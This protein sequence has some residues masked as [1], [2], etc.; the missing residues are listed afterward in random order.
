MNVFIGS[1]SEQYAVAN[2]VRRELLLTLPP[3]TVEIITWREWFRRGENHGLNT[4]EVISRATSRF[5]CA[6]MLLA[7]D[8]VTIVRSQEYVSTRD[9]VLIESGAFADH[10]GIDRVF[11]LVDKDDQYRVAS[12]YRGLNVILYDY[13]RG[14]ENSEAFQTIREKIKEIVQTRLQEVTFPQEQTNYKTDDQIVRKEK[15]G[16]I[17]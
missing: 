16:K 13:E 3:N 1:S 10:L 12:D 15:R 9:N 11:L 5:D 4:W 7:G 17:K 8:D 6:I 2:E 14:A